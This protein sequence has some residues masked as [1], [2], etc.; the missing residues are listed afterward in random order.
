MRG[1]REATRRPRF[2]VRACSR[3]HSRERAWRKPNTP[4]NAPCAR[5]TRG[6]KAPRWSSPGGAG[7]WSAFRAARRGSPGMRASGPR[8]QGSQA[9]SIMMDCVECGQESSCG[10]KGTRRGVGPG[11]AGS[12]PKPTPSATGTNERACWQRWFS[13]ANGVDPLPPS[14][15]LEEAT[16][17]VARGQMDK[18]ELTRW[19]RDA[20]PLGKCDAGRVRMPCCCASAANPGLASAICPSPHL[21][22]TMSA[23]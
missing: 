20:P 12:R 22:S 19:F 9:A 17:A 3:P 10:R 18:A 16:F 21:P 7:R 23:L 5:R 2:I 14:E 6:G 1:V 15:E 11:S 4:S 8:S 13:C